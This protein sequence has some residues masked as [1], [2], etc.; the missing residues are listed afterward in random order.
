MEATDK[1]PVGLLG[2]TGAVGQKFLNLLE[3]DDTFRVCVLGASKRSSGKKYKDIVQ[4]H[5]SC[6][7]MEV[8]ECDPEH[9]KSCKI[10]FS[11]LDA[12]VAGDIEKLFCE[13]GYAV[14]S[15]AK[16]WRMDPLVPLCVP[17]CNP[18]HLNLVKY[19]RKKWNTTGML[20]TNANCSTTGIAIVLKAIAPYTKLEQ[21]IVHTLQA[22][23]GAGYPG[24]SVMDIHDNVIP[25]ISGE[26][27]KIQTET[28]KILGELRNNSIVLQDWD[29]TAICNRVNVLDGHT[30]NVLIKSKS[31]IDLPHIIEKLERLPFIRVMNE[32][33]RPQPRLDRVYDMKT[34]VGRF[35]L[36][37]PNLLSFCIVS[38]NTVLGA[39]GSSIWNAKKAI[40]MKL[41]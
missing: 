16:N 22:V 34:S 12:E 17:F 1:I 10:I 39:A 14:F 2:A 20:V 41:I 19:Q 18:D 28:L 3:I 31:D 7:D 35:Q 40:E 32:V 29:I 25:Y 38:H 36:K 30:V 4:L 37:K 11:A 5:L 27:N 23:S 26:E 24:L 8:F 13:Q 21:L 33:N 9:F 15:N 6:D